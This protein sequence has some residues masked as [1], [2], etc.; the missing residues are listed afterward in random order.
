MVPHP[1]ALKKKK[2]KKKKRGLRDEMRQNTM[3]E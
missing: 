3:R 2:E 1:A